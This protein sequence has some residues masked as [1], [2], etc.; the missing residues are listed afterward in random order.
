MLKEREIR[1]V[2][3][4]KYYLSGRR[5]RV[6][7]FVLYLITQLKFTTYS[8]SVMKAR[9]RMESRINYDEL[10]YTAKISSCMLKI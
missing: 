7:N 10:F 2:V 3:N 1:S 8:T 9:I 6:K 5:K 4:L